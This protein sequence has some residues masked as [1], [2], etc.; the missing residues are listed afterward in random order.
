MLLVNTLDVEPWWTSTPAC[1]APEDWKDMS[2]RSEAPLREYMDLCDAAGVKCTFFF[3]GWYAENFP[4]RVREAVARGHEVGCH[5]LMH[6]DIATLSDS[7]FRVSTREAKDRIEQVVGSAIQAYRAPCFTFPPERTTT[8]LHELVD[9]GF[10]I[11]SSI[12][13]AGRIHGGGHSKADF[14]AP[15]NLKD[16]HGVD[17]FEIPVPGVNV[18]GRDLTVFGGGYLRLAPRAVL[19]H[20]ARQEEYQVLYLHPHDFDL[21]LPPLPV[22]GPIAQLRRRLHVGDIRRKVI[23]LFEANTVVSCGQLAAGIS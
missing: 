6:E 7:E 19:N 21:D 16:T 14:P 4:D 5:S 12:T 17:I 15:R 23:D 1:V 20:L 13:T 8:L 10:T 18:G 22:G 3:V 11:D 2:D 9:L